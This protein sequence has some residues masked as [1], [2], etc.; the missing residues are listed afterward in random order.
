M[1]RGTWR[2]RGL[3]TLLALVFSLMSEAAGA[4][5]AQA[6]VRRHIA[7]DPFAQIS[8]ER[9]LTRLEQLTRIGA[10]ELFR[11]SASRGGPTATA[12]VSA[13]TSNPRNILTICAI[14]F[15]DRHPSLVA[16]R[17][18]SHQSASVIHGL[19]NRSRSFHCD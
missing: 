12:I 10:A 14:F 4:Q 16:P 8:A 19:A 2:S 17:H 9:A 18:G 5:V 1:Q 13:C 6:R 7:P 3:A 11:T 15:I